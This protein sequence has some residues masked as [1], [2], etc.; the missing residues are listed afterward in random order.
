MISALNTPKLELDSVR[1]VVLVSGVLVDEEVHI[2]N[3][4]KADVVVLRS[5]SLDLDLSSNKGSTDLCF[6]GA[7]DGRATGLGTRSSS[8]LMIEI[9]LCILCEGACKLRFGSR[10]L[11]MLDLLLL[12]GRGGLRSGGGA[13]IL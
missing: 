10:S 4:F 3:E 2:F 9:E 1:D 8:F 11:G 7:S 13:D 5:R 6:S 12:F